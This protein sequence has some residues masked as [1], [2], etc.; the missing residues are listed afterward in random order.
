MSSRKVLLTQAVVG[1][2]LLAAA[3]FWAPRGPATFSIAL[4]LVTIFSL[5]SPAQPPADP[6]AAARK[7]LDLLIA[8]KYTELRTLLTVQG[9]ERLTEEALRNQVGGRIRTLG[10]LNSIGEPVTGKDGPDTLVSFPLRFAAM[11]VNIQ[12]TLNRSLQVAS[13]AFRPADAPLPKLWQR[14]PYSHPESFTE[15]ELSVGSDSWQLGATLTL[16]T[17]KGPFPAVVLVHGP[18]PNDRDESIYSNRVFRDLGEGLASRGIAVLRYDKRTFAYADKMGDLEFTIEQETVEDAT[19]A[20]ALL[21]TRPEIASNRIYVL[22]HSLGGYALPR[23]AAHDR[24]LAGLVFL[25][26]N[27]RPIE[28]VALD[29]NDY[30][31]HLNGDPTPQVLQRLEAL[32]AEVARVKSLHPGQQAPQVLM[33][34][35]GAYLLDLRGYDAAA[36]AKQLGIPMLF[37]QGGRDFQVTGKDFEIWKTALSARDDA[38]FKQYPSLNH[39]F[40]AGDGPSSPAEYLKAANVDPAVVSDI[41]NWVSQAQASSK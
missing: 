29:Q 1:R 5:V 25:A 31:A 33:G 40:M 18:G 2:P 8:E 16:P 22:G 28:D 24:K 15:R 20:V 38:T 21:R 7:A 11:N 6:A 9:R 17:G 4:A 26:A 30:V 35:P 36:Q 34:L 12:F 23:I 41:A 27:A 3:G 13:L 39:L 19:R 32:K 14:P 37:L 10:E